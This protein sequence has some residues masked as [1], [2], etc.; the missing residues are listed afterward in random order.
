MSAIESVEAIPIGIPLK[1]PLRWGAAGRI[2]RLEHVLVRIRTRDGI[3][4]W[5]EAAPRPMIYGESLSSVMHALTQWFG[6]AIKGMDCTAP[7]TIV[8]SMDTV[9]GNP[10]AKSAIELAVYDAAARTAGMPL[11]RYL[12]GWS[13]EVQVG[14]MLSIGVLH[15]VV[16]EA[17]AVKRETGINGF[18]I[19]AGLNPD[20]DVQLIKTLR[21]ELGPDA[22]LYPDFNEQY[23]LHSAI[24]AINE[25]AQYGIAWVEEPIP[26]A[27]HEQRLALARALAVPILVDDSATTLPAAARQLASGIAGVLCIKVARTGIRQSQRILA[28]G[29]AFGVKSLV[30]SQGL[31]DLGTCHSAEFAAAYRDVTGPADLGNFIKQSDFVLDNSLAIKDGKLRLSGLSGIG[32]DVSDAALLRLRI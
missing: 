24:R 14:Y 8:A 10:S 20:E 17:L 31:T 27:Q 2:E 19:K 21:H 15:D 16:A 11:R 4:G 18:K 12:G 28:C 25:M 26:V 7:E 22:V 30:G 1:R 3:V 29:A 9:A 5:G 13:N 32:V 23:T 6:P